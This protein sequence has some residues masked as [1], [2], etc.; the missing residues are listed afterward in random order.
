MRS[1]TVQLTNKRFGKDSR[2]GIHLKS[3]VQHELQRALETAERDQ[4]ETIYVHSRSKK[5]EKMLMDAV[6]LMEEDGTHVNFTRR[7][8]YGFEFTI[9]QFG[10]N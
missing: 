4:F 1:I 8:D 6:R 2:Q 10:A 9:Y 3:P 7:T 5:V